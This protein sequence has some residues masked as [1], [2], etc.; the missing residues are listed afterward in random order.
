METNIKEKKSIKEIEMENI[1]EAV[2]FTMGKSVEVRQ[3][4]VAMDCG[5]EEAYQIARNLQ[6][7]YQEENRSLEI[8][9]LENCFQMCTKQEYY[10]PLIKVA[11]APKKQVL[12]EATLETL[13][14]IA[15][16]QPVTR[17]EIENIR[18]VSSSYSINKLVEYGL[19]YEVGRLEVIGRPVL[20]ATTE[21]FLR[22][23]GVGSKSD[24]P[25]I[26]AEMEEKIVHEVEQ[27][28]NYKFGVETQ[29]EKR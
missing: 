3:L 16:K 6:K 19:V 11:K 1:V 28:V 4:A 29:E 7:R 10:E 18:G 8:L 23:F 22:R 13:S 15:Y 26:Q 21:D 20:F 24:L 25:K 14:I 2:L 9:E 5:I 12:T 17:A 27:E